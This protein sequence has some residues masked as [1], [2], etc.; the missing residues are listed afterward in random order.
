MEASL[1]RL[2]A[3]LQEERIFRFAKESEA[4]IVFGENVTREAIEAAV[5]DL[6]SIGYSV[7]YCCLSCEELG[8]DHK[9][10]RYWFLAIKDQSVFKKVARSLSKKQKVMTSQ[11]Y[12]RIYCS[13]MTENS[14]TE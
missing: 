5:E 6:K 4:P 9:R 1:A 14:N 8:A 3:T 10:V 12:A 11:K 2:L 13:I 7:K